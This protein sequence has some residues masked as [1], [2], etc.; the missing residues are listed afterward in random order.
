VIPLLSLA[1]ARVLILLRGLQGG[2]SPPVYLEF[3]NTKQIAGLLGRGRKAPVKRRELK[4]LHEAFEIV[5]FDFYT[6][7][8]RPPKGYVD[9]M[10]E[11][12]FK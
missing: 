7:L 6:V 5:F 11:L 10:V 1:R 9:L 4:S 8:I 3:L 2:L 12:G